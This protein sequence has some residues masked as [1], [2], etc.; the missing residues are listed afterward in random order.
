MYEDILLVD[1]MVT[2]VLNIR[3]LSELSDLEHLIKVNGLI[4]LDT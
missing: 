2:K 1:R 3:W 4:G